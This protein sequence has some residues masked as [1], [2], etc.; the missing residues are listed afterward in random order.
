MM[1]SRRKNKIR[2]KVK[3]TVWFVSYSVVKLVLN[4]Q[5]K[6]LVQNSKKR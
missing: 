4:V 1:V 6:K 2:F 5:K 3:R